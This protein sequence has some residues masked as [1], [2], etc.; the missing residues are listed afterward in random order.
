MPDRMA[1]VM[2]T[3]REIE[4]VSRLL[5]D[6]DRPII[7]ELGAHCGEDSEWMRQACH[8]LHMLNVMVEPD[9]R[10]VEIIRH[11]RRGR[12]TVIIEAAIADYTGMI[13]FNLAIDSRCEGGRSGSGS[14][15]EPEGHRITFPEIHF[16]PGVKV[17]CW[18]LDHLCASLG[19]A[20]IDVLWVD[21]QGAERDVI[22]G[23][24]EALL[25]TRYIFVESERV[26]LYQGQALRDELLELLPGFRV[27]EEFDYNLLLEAR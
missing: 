25:T 22:A 16:V 4:V 26:E 20:K 24:Q 23:G 7:V 9:H 14:I 27:I 11:D 12:K 17:P 18:S 13:D 10:N 1:K 5:E 6:L 19:V 21:V 8:D 2:S 3:E 15:R